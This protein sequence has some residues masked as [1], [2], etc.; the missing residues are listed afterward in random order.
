VKR[1]EHIGSLQI[2]ALH[3][4][5][6]QQQQ[7]QQKQQKQAQHS[8][9]HQG[10]FSTPALQQP[11]MGRPLPPFNQRSSIK[12][13]LPNSGSLLTKDPSQDVFH[14]TF[15]AFQQRFHLQLSPNTHLLHPNA[16]LSTLNGDGQTVTSSQRLS[17][18][19]HRIRP[20]S[21]RVLSEY[22]AQDIRE[23]GEES[24]YLAAFDTEH[25]D[26]LGWARITFF[27]VDHQ[28][29]LG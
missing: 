17:D 21:G 22:Q 2:H 14:L 6:A 5:H 23:R 27:D 12:E 9:Q 16:L 10:D 3:H 19:Q 13:P 28:L 4:H 18:F 15:E 7:K 29:P 26:D 8:Q 25:P 24:P 11:W 20:Y 1:Y